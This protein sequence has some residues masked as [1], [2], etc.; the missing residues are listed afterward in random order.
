MKQTTYMFLLEMIASDPPQGVQKDRIIIAAI[1]TNKDAGT[2]E[3]REET[4]LDG[5]VRD[6]CANLPM[7]EGHSTDSKPIAQV[8]NV[9]EDG[10]VSVTMTKSDFDRINGTGEK[11][12]AQ[13]LTEDD[14][15]NAAANDIRVDMKEAARLIG[16]DS[17][18]VINNI[19]SGKIKG[20]CEGSARGFHVRIGD[21]RK[22]I[23]RGFISK[24]NRAMKKEAVK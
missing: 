20:Y 11:I 1:G 22:F 3:R 24:S 21:I 15:F 10:M 7:A 2:P 18:T 19:K 17:Q 23:G 6:N 13:R 5:F 8:D 14:L 12:P 9:T 4:T 16:C